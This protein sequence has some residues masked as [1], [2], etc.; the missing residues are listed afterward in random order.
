[1]LI[2]YS[3]FDAGPYQTAA[4]AVWDS[5]NK[6]ATVTLSGG[7]LTA[8]NASGSGY[9]D[10]ISTGSFD[11]ADRYGFYFET[12]VNS[13]AFPNILYVGLVPDGTLASDLTGA[14]SSEGADVTFGADGWRRWTTGSGSTDEGADLSA[15]FVYGIFVKDGSL[16]IQDDTY[17]W[18]NSADPD[19]GTGA[20]VTGLTGLH[21]P[22]LSMLSA[23]MTGRFDPSSW[24]L[25][26]PVHAKYVEAP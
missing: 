13:A 1:M 12:R 15:P 11:A 6:D 5:G 10:V 14:W 4:S 18:W 9:H 16:Y 21:R 20:L 8:A 19:A 3:I 17:G 26:P 25:T 2:P 22:A 7:D 23:N 24:T